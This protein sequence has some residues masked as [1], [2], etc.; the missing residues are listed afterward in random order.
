MFAALL[1][2]VLKYAIAFV[3]FNKRREKCAA[4]DRRRRRRQTEGISS[5]DVLLFITCLFSQIH[6]WFE[7]QLI[8]QSSHLLAVK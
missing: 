1:D 8:S 6:R 2:E 7:V 4:E 3:T 5:Y